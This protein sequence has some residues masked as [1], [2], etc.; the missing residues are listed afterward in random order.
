MVEKSLKPNG[1]KI[2][3]WGDLVA[4]ASLLTLFIGVLAWGLKLEAELNQVRADYGHRI[5]DLETRVA[6]GILPRAEE[7]IE[8]HRQEITEIKRRLDKIE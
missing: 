6:D 2:R 1:Y 5:S 3:S 8:F 4:L 7:R